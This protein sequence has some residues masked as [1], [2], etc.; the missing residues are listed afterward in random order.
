MI[1]ISEDELIRR[2]LPTQPYHRTGAHLVFAPAVID[3][4][5]QVFAPYARRWVEAGCFWYG[6]ESPDGNG[7]VCA[8][9][10]P[11]QLNYR[12]WYTV[13]AAAMARV[14][15]LTRGRRWVN[16]AQIH[17]HPGSWVEHSTYDDLH[18]NS[19]RALSVVLPR[20]GQWRGIWP[21]GIGLHECQDGY[22]HLLSS[23][24]A[25]ERTRMAADATTV[26]LVIAR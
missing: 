18:A 10:V 2:P 20:Y 21:E 6:S 16:L 14:A 8:V 24:I 9:V 5:V 4:T 19:R 3:L 22:W 26:Q 13:G 7:Q 25:A 17:T 1:D 11:A 12:G 15:E 23:A